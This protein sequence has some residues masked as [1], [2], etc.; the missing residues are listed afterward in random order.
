MSTD[1]ISAV[2]LAPHNWPLP[3]VTDLATQD[4]P[5]DSASM[6]WWYVNTHVTTVAGRFAKWWPPAASRCLT[7]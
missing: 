5:H 2:A 1:S 6:E 7:C 4:L 3:G